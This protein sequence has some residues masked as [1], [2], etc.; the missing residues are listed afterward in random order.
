M[1]FELQ[2][3]LTGDRV[4]LRPL[5][6]SDWNELFQVASDRLIWE[7]HPN[8][9][10][11]QEPV[12][13][14]FFSGAM[15]SGGAFAAVDPAKGVIIGSTRYYGLNEED[16][17]IEIGW[18]FLAR[19]YWGGETNREMKRMML[20]HAFK[21]VHSVLFSIGPTNYRSQLAVLKI[22]A[23]RDGSR[24]S[25]AGQESFIYRIGPDA[26]ILFE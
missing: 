12:F 4:I 18:T 6:E 17:E 14:E 13:R 2:P 3:T 16:S 25:P 19:A 24:I 10:R 1:P 22:G 9:D 7:Q 5:Q 20:Q 21:Y 8:N 23:V 15:A 26:A 11:Y